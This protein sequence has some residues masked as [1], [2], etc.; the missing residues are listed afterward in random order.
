MPSLPVIT[1]PANEHIRSLRKLRDRKRRQE[2]ALFLA[3]G[4]RIVGEALSQPTR[5]KEV[6]YCPALLKQ[7]YARQALDQ[8]R[9]SGVPVQELSQ[10]AFTALSSRDGPQ[11]LLAV[12]RQEWTPLSE[13]NP[14]PGHNWVALDSIADPGN[15]GTI[16][17]TTDAAGWRGV[18][19]LDSTTDPYDPTAVRASMGS[20][21]SQKVVRA[22]FGGFKAWVQTCGIPVIG[23]SGAA[24]ADYASFIYPDPMVLLMGSEREGLAQ[25]HLA[26][27]REVVSIPMQGRSDSLNLAVSTGIVL[28][29]ILNQHRGVSRACIPASLAGGQGGSL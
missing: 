18:I 9:K 19:L 20:L 23:T 11:G 22:D 13:I 17:R 3:E 1:S 2:E 26:L 10:A 15:L 25:H 16:L 8:A 14:K 5:V 27:C 28:Y 7:E 21:F 6:L 24:S 29:E 12:I 4:L